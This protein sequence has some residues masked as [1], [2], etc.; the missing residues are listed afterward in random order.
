M[1]VLFAALPRPVRLVLLDADTLVVTD[2]MRPIL[3]PL[4]PV[5]AAAVLA[6]LGVDMPVDGFTG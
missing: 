4:L 6:S 5:A 2:E 1:V 3:A